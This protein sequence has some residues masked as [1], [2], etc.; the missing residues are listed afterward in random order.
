MQ[1]VADEVALRHIFSFS[2]SIFPLQIMIPPML[3]SSEAGTMGPLAVQ[4]QGTQSHPS[5]TV[6]LS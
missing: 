5:T 1:F 4:V 6:T 3:L 2:T